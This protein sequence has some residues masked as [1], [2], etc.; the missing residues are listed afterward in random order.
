MFM[1]AFPHV[2]LSRAELLFYF[3]CIKSL[4]KAFD[5][6]DHDVNLVCMEYRS[7]LMIGLS[8]T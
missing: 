7:L 2:P 4:K 5:T 6:V 8:R 1:I 3:L